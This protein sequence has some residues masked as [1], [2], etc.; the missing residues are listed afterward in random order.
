MEVGMHV[1]KRSAVAALAVGALAGSA[2][3]AVTASGHDNRT[4]GREHRGEHPRETLLKTTLAPSVPT[5]PAIDAVSPG[6]VPWVLARGEA[7]LRANGDL[8]LEVRGLLIPS[9][10]FAGTTGPVTTVSASLYCGGTVEGRTPSTQLSSH[11]NADMD[12]IVTVPAKCLAPTVLV[13]PNGGAAAYI[14]AS[15]F[16]G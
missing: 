14:A 4:N 8:R 13:H 7:R 12:G 3:S 10:Q 2:A 9:G 1:S 11:G 6:G 15:G 16:G 5:D